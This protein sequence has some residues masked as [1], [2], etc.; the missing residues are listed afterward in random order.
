MDDSQ[1]K[2]AEMGLL[3]GT[4]P[5]KLKDD[6]PPHGALC[7]P[8]S[9]AICLLIETLHACICGCGQQRMPWLCGLL[10]SLRPHFGLHLVLNDEGRTSVLV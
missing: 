9:V 4:P 8:A 10:S 2:P 3:K 6:N 5:E 7:L 1:I